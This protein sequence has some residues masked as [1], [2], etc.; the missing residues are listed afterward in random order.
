MIRLD[1]L[2]DATLHVTHAIDEAVPH[3]PL[4]PLECLHPN[5][6]ANR[7]RVIG[8]GQMGTLCMTCHTLDTGLADLIVLAPS[9][10][11]LKTSGWLAAAV[12]DISEQLARNG[13]VYGLIPRPWRWRAAQLLRQCGLPAED[14]FLHLPNWASSRYLVPL[15]SGPAAYA[16]SMLIPVRPTRRQLMLA[17]LRLP[18]GTLILRDLLP[19]I[20][21]VSRRRSQR[22]LFAWAFNASSAPPGGATLSFNASGQSS[23]LVLHLFEGWQS[24]P[25]AVLKRLWSA[26]PMADAPDEAANLV[27]FRYCVQHA[28]AELPALLAVNQLAGQPVLVESVVRGRSAAALLTSKGNRFTQVMERLTAWL[29]H[30]Q[31]VTASSGADDGHWLERE[32]LS[33][34]N[35]LAALL[36][37]HTAYR[38]W[39]AE[40]GHA[41][42]NRVPLVAA[43]H[44]LTMWNVL[45][46][47]DGGLGIVDWAAAHAASL[48]LTDFCYAFVDAA[49]IARHWD[50]QRACG[51]SFNVGGKLAPLARAWLKRLQHPLQISNELAEFC[52]HACFLRHAANESEFAAP[53]QPQPFLQII[54]WL[55]QNRA[56]IHRWIAADA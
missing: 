2:R 48:P 45:L 17:L 52:V 32:C 19:W 50:R 46:T 5:G 11:E 33:P 16:L 6:S 44:D 14:Y 39:L 31:R 13:I 25:S 20:G 3:R 10:S 35:R 4:S 21:F 22:P 51:E 7:V 34:A 40:Q 8:S 27:A 28:G 47:E 12:Q 23:S 26:A 54:H 1:H 53:G 49:V 37:S 15:Q 41:W 56:A 18:G 9:C 42:L 36:G 55:A 29:E 38:L 24:H 30:W 43:H